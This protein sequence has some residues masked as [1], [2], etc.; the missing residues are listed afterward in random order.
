MSRSLPTHC[1]GMPADNTTAAQP[2]LARLPALLAEAVAAHQ[3][4]DLDRAAPLYRSF[5]EQE[6]RNPTALQLFG[7]LHSQR[8]EY[9]QAIDLME[10]SLREFPQQAEVANN[11]AN[12]LAASGRLK[13]AVDTYGRALRIR[14]RYP[15][16]FRNLGLCYLQLGIPEDAEVCF[17]RCLGLDQRDAAAWVGLGNA[18]RAQGRLEEA[19]RSYEQALALRPDY[20]EA[21]HN[22][23]VCRRLQHRPQEALAHYRRARELGLDRAELYQNIGTAHVDNHEL[24][25]AIDAYRAAVERDPLDL[26]S[27]RALNKLLFE[28]EQDEDYL[29][30]YRRALKQAP[31]FV[32]LRQAL[33]VA[34]NQQ[35]AY[36]EAERVLMEGL[37]DAPNSC[38]LKS[39]LAY[40]LEGQGRWTEALQLHAAAVNLPDATPNDRVSY[41]RALL[42]C[43][44]PDEALPQAEQAAAQIPDNQRAIAYLGLCWRMLGDERDA[45]LNDYEEFV[46]SYDIPVPPGFSSADEFNAR[47]RQVLEKLHVTRRHPP[48]QTLRGGT[49]TYGDLFDRRE[50]EI[51]ALMQGLSHCIQDYIGHLPPHPAHPLLARRSERFAFSASW[52]VRLSPCGFHTMHIHPLGWISSAYYVQVPP[53]V[54]AS[55]DAGGGIKFG[56]PDIDLGEQGKAR[57]LIQPASGRL[58]LFPSYMWH[59]TVPFQSGMPRMTVA[60]D[61][62]PARG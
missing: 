39:L 42:A 29:G 47:L 33:A 8:G 38:A 59:G 58:V 45:I 36:E 1:P 30:S 24:Q 25:A 15:E 46:R 20:P 9:A 21:H 31:G 56:E 41:A 49:Q 50:P 40:T 2:Q 57:R 52:S 60:F 16:A 61:V 28:L 22:L 37:R 53:E 44:R 34:L 10:R 4:G 26:D 48:E 27:H 43:R 6:P 51:V 14:P 3:S 32:P 17:R 35:G 7:L 13:E 54:T 11:L 18:Q 62:V 12:A 55:E 5:L 19:A 23:G